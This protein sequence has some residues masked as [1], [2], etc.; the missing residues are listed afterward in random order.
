M[1]AELQRVHIVEMITNK[2]KIYLTCKISITFAQNCCSDCALYLE[3][4]AKE[5]DIDA[6]DIDDVIADSDD[7]PDNHSAQQKNVTISLQHE[8]LHIQQHAAVEASPEAMAPLPDAS[9]VQLTRIR[10]TNLFSMLAKRQETIKP[11]T[12]H[13]DTPISDE[14]IDIFTGLPPER[15]IETIHHAEDAIV[16][17]WSPTQLQEPEESHV[18]AVTQSQVTTLPID[19]SPTT[20]SPTKA[21][22]LQRVHRQLHQFPGPSKKK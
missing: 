9:R 21:R 14:E 11:A 6:W 16:D 5:M 8:P 4:R 7:L 12:E 22:K 20:L 10:K 13:P 2:G 15:E 19:T 17:H 1:R 3:K 18:N